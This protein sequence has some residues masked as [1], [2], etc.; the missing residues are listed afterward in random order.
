MMATAKAKGIG[1]G[2]LVVIAIIVWYLFIRDD[3]YAAH[4]AADIASG[5]QIEVPE[6]GTDNIID[7][8]DAVA[9]TSNLPLSLDPSVAGLPLPNSTGF[10][11][12][13]L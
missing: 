4:L 3:S 2:A 7:A 1:I 13:K 6:F 9:A 8:A 11:S 5:K 12:L 10:P